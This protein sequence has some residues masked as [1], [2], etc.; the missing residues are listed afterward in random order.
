GV[1]KTFNPDADPA[2]LLRSFQA[3]MDNFDPEECLAVYRTTAQTCGRQFEPGPDRTLF[4]DTYAMQAGY[5]MW[6]YGTTQRHLA[7]A[8]CKSHHHGSLNPKA[9]YQFDVSVEQV[10]ADRVVSPPLTRSMCAPIGDGAAAALLCSEDYL[11]DVP[12][13]VRERAV[14]VKAS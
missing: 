3:G 12:A 5:H 14:Q 2:A 8:A 9:Q 7:I 13:A 6:L 11:K 10:L 4:M 1:E